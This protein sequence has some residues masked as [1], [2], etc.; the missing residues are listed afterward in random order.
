[1]STNIFPINEFAT[2]TEDNERLD[3]QPLNKYYNFSHNS[4]E[5]EMLASQIAEAIQAT[6]QEMIYLPRNIQNLD[7]VFGEDPSNSFETSYRFAI[8]VD[9]V[10]TWVGEDNTITKL[11]LEWD[12]SLNCIVEQNFLGF[13]L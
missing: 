7:I 4:G 13:L 9:D 6:G 8:R 2:N 11:G 5:Q 10:E 3:A 12:A 1:M